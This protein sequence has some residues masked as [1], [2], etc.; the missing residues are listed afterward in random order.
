MTA[1]TSVIVVDHE[2]AALPGGSRV[3]RSLRANPSFWIGSV[4]VVL[5]VLAAILAPVLAQHD[6][7]QQFRREGLNDHGDPI[8]PSA[9]FAARDRPPRARRTQSTPVRRPDVA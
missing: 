5:I 8:G 3:W 4:M 2:V 1:Q 9:D 6:P 7:D